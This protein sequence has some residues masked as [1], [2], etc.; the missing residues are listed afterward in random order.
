LRDLTNIQI[1]VIVLIGIVIGFGVLTIPQLLNN[2]LNS[3]NILDN[4]KQDTRGDTFPFIPQNFSIIKFNNTPFS[5][6]Q[7]ENNV[8]S[9]G[10]SKDGIP[11]IEDPKYVTGS[12]ADAYLADTDIVF[13]LDYGGRVIAFPQ[14]ILVWH[15]LVNENIGGQRISIAYCPLTG[16]VVGF[17]GHF[18]TV[19]TTF[20][21]SG[22]LLN[23]NLVMYDRD[24]DSFWPQILGEAINGPY[25][26]EQLEKVQIIWTT[27]EKWFSQYPETEVLSEDTGYV[28]SYGY[29]PYGSYA[30]DNTYYQTGSPFFPVMT[31]DSTL[32]DKTIVYGVSFDGSTIAIEKDLLRSNRVINLEL[33]N[34]RIVAFYD[35]NLDTARVYKSTVEGQDY[36]F[37]Y[38][39][40]SLVDLTTNTTW[41]V[42]GSSVIGSLEPIV[43]FD[44]MWFSW[45]AF[46]PDTTLVLSNS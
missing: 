27:W 34:Q 12:E 8:Q 21:V 2:T 30:S 43:Y 41:S 4:S 35:E 32:S 22:N 15:E 31:S 36:A 28:R 10:V 38:I 40:G 25:Q 42:D 18:L 7:F 24:S 46:Y 37:D 16:S 26:G 13:G 44:V 11:P 33:S 3:E 23:S 39:N 9:G 17:K 45:F 14:Y 20:G 1:A 19:E 29:D 6:S 5:H